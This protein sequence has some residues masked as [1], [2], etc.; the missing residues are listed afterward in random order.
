MQSNQKTQTQ[1]ELVDG[2][3]TIETALK[4]RGHNIYS[5]KPHYKPVPLQW[6][7]PQQIKVGKG[8]TDFQRE[9]Q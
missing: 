5:T 7:F 8:D 3:Y 2:K 4:N 6:F 9:W 1:D